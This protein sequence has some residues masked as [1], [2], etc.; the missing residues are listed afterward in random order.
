M[1]HINM[2]CRADPCFL[3]G[4]SKSLS[5]TWQHMDQR[6][7]PRVQWKHTPVRDNEWPSIPDGDGNREK[8]FQIAYMPAELLLSI[9]IHEVVCICGTK[10]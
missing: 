5:T 1:D 6:Q 2:D 3:C 10:R 8:G 7:I 9:A 4:G